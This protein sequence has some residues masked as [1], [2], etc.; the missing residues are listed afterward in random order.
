MSV[1]TLYLSWAHAKGTRDAL[2]LEE[3]EGQ[4]AV[5]KQHQVYMDSLE[6]LI[7]MFCEAWGITRVL[8]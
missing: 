7:A 5:L 6:K 3:R 8:P 1:M 2:L 4:E